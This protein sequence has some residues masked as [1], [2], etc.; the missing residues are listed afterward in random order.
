MRPDSKTLAEA[1]I[2]GI[3]NSQRDVINIGMVTSDMAVFAIKHL[4][5]SGAAIIT[6][7]HN[8]GEYNGVKLYD[9]TPKTIGLDQGLD[10]IR[11]SAL[12]STQP[13]RSEHPATVKTISL[14]DEW[15][16]FALGKIDSS[17][18]PV[19]KIAIDAGNG[20][21]GTV[22][23][24]LLKKLPQLTV[25]Q[26]YFTPDGTFP[27]HLANPQDLSTLKDLQN[28]I[29]TKQLDLG[30]AFDGDGDRMAMVD[31]AGVPISG[32]EM[33]SLLASKYIT[34]DTSFVHEVRTSR[35]VVQRLESQSGSKAVRSKSGRS[36][37]G[38]L[39]SANS[40]VFGGETTG[41]FFFKEYWNNDSGLLAMLI[42]LEQ[43][44]ASQV[45]PVSALIQKHA[46]GAMAPETN[47]SV[48]N[49]DQTISAIAQH[50]EQYT[51]DTLDGLS[52]AEEDWWFNI[53]KSN[54]E[55]L[56]R[57]NA[58]AATTEKLEQLINSIT[59]VITATV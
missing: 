58:E 7:S 27:N 26:L 39:M 24:T 35:V 30:V 49:A 2:E 44:S 37:I 18:I 3:V 9:S 41:H 59:E 11:D 40:S 46:T 54:T 4:D 42:A 52:V 12:S 47:F 57:L 34:A 1:L 5:A 29:I 56:I 14:I 33:F 36:N 50:F 55:P 51:Q 6:A 8:P 32:S 22:L 23:P 20:M 10:S 28:T 16:D 38:E 43:I 45:Q 21:A 53:R 17:K 31:E 25:E 15:V 13:P 48:T 19:L